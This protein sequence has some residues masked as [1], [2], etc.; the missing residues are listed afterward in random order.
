MIH[1]RIVRSSPKD[2]GITV[3]GIAKFDDWQAS[4]TRRTSDAPSDARPDAPSV[5][6]KADAININDVPPVSADAP[7]DAGGETKP[8]QY[9]DNKEERKILRFPKSKGEAT[10]SS[11]WPPGGFERWYAIYPR[12]KKPKDARRAFA[13][14]QASAEISF[15]DLMARTERYAAEVKAWPKDRWQYIPYPGS[16]LNSGSFADEPDGPPESRAATPV[17][18]PRSFSESEWQDRL[19]ANSESATW[20]TLWGP[21]PGSPG[22]IVPTHLV[23]VVRGAGHG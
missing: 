12:K 20:S 16:W 7:S 18:D 21:P 13:K 5:D 19:R 17:R 4:N 1:R 8:T 3:I 23:S 15:V 14:L 2:R 22:C 11:E 9:I 10:A 6:E